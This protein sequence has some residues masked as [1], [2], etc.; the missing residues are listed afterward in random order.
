MRITGIIAEYNPLHNGHI[1]HMSEARQLSEAD[2]IVAVM[3]GN[4]VQ[5]GEPALADKYLRTKAALL[6]GADAVFELPVRYSCGSAGFF[7]AG[8]VSALDSLAV[9]DGIAFGCEDADLEA[10]KSM[11]AFLE[12]EPEEYKKL[13]QSN[14]RRGMNFAKARSKALSDVLSSSA[15]SLLDKP[16]NILAIEYLRA[17]SRTG[18]KLTPYA[19]ARTGKGHNESASFIR[20]ELE[21]I[22]SGSILPSPSLQS[23]LPAYALEDLSCPLFSDDFSGLLLYRLR[24]LTADELTRFEDISPE[25]AN[26]IKKASASAHSF[27][28]LAR[29]VSSRAFT[30]SRIR[31]ALIHI[32]IDLQKKVTADKTAFVTPSSLSVPDGATPVCPQ[33]HK[34]EALRLL[35]FR[36]GTKVLRL[37]QDA[38]AVP[39]ITKPADAPDECLTEDILATDIYRLAFFERYKL[40]LPDEYRSGPIIV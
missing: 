18:S 27:S 13:L 40:P 6:A 5:R 2:G 12:D 39:I 23:M 21:K 34:P 25:L 1:Y 31:R 22:Q 24:L 17:M 32:L 19:V 26:S 11:A 20:K 36:R 9:V 14:M 4:F 15:S 29:A 37:I 8:G 30:D 10:L 7:A 3:S 16:N 33:A 35:G 28:E 38:A